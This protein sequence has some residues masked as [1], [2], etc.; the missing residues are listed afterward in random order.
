MKK[1]HK[2]CKQVAAITDEELAE[3]SAEVEAQVGYVHPL[4]YATASA[5]RKAGSHN[6]RVLAAFVALRDVILKGSK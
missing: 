2:I 3:V 5:V 1:L 6:Q 4:K